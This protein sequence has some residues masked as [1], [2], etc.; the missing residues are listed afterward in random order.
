VLTRLH[1]RPSR[2]VLVVEDDRAIADAV[3]RRL[4]SEGYA[5]DAVAD[6]LAAV[7]AATRAADAG[8]SYDVVVLDLML[9]GIDG[10]EVCRRIQAREP[11]P[12]LML[13][14]RSD[15]DDR[16]TGLAVGADDYL[17]KP[18][19][20]R[21]LVARVA[22]LVRRVDRATA[23]AAAAAAGSGPPAGVVDVGELRVDV[24]RR[25][26]SVEGEPVHLTRTEFDLLCALARRPGEVIGRERLLA[27][28]WDWTDAEAARAAATSAVRAVDSHVKSL[29]RK[30]GAARIRTA[31]G[32]GYALEEQ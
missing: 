28:V 5:V 26:V 18:F 14:A 16:L 6:G 25:T 19:S 30:V 21:E 29:R 4:E 7:A 31:H 10:L 23:L 9:P 20:P 17:T 1:D 3:R 27:E 22:A 32:V 13:T 8:V 12:V 15:E 11:V 24:A 2:R